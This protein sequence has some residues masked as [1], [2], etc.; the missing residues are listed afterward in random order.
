MATNW[1][2]RTPIPNKMAGI[3]N[4]GTPDEKLIPLLDRLPQRAF[5]MHDEDFFKASLRHAH[6][7]LVPCIIHNFG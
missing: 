2:L 7:A 1:E 6:Y 4:Y 5:F 3:S